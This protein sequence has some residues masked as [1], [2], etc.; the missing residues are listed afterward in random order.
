MKLFTLLFATCAALASGVAAADTIAPQRA[1]VTAH[2]DHHALAEVKFGF[3]SAVLPGDATHLMQPA[4]RYA[5]HHPA[6]R[7]I[8]D[9]HCDPIGTSP[10]NVRL[11][12]RRA[13]SVKKQLTAA[14]VPEEQ[15]VLAI[16]GED[17]PRRSTYAADRRVTLWATNQPI[18][19]VTDHTF[20]Q[21][22][23]AVEWGRP[24]TTAQIEARPQPVTRGASTV[25]TRR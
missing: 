10:Y 23:T 11:A 5:A 9:A 8:V 15:I 13:E 25:A 18:A 21:R 14:G 2:R 20:A 24:L 7:I 1:A 12:I 17:G 4:I 16:Y 6:A 19:S 3:D 22:G